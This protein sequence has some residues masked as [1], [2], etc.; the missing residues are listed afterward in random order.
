VSATSD[1][2]LGVARAHLGRASDR[3]REHD[4]ATGLEQ[5]RYDIEDALSALDRA[6]YSVSGAVRSSGA[7][8]M[9]LAMT[10]ADLSSIADLVARGNEV[11]EALA[12]IRARLRDPGS[13]VLERLLAVVS[14]AAS[15]PL[16]DRLAE[17]SDELSYG[18]PDD[19]L[20]RARAIEIAFRA[21]LEWTRLA[22]L[23]Q[24]DEAVALGL[25][26]MGN[27]EAAYLSRALREDYAPELHEPARTAALAAAD[28]LDLARDFEAPARQPDPADVADWA[29]ASLIALVKLAAPEVYDLAAQTVRDLQDTRRLQARDLR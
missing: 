25:A 9:Q 28:A 19:A 13:P 14:S 3:L 1:D 10:L 6:G 24:G 11:E 20:E 23:R 15:R 29:A 17:L 5:A 26:S 16:H 12:T 22:A 8:R 27:V 21:G 7:S 2:A 18:V 4:G